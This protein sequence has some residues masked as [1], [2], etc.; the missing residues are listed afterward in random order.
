MFTLPNP[1][2]FEGFDPELEVRL[3]R[4]HLPHW[5]QDGA[6]YFLT[7]RTAD[8]IPASKA[9]EL[10]LLKGEIEAAS[11]KDRARLEAAWRDFV[12]LLERFLDEGHGACVLRDPELSEIVAGAMRHFDGERY[13]LFAYT[14]M[15]NHVHAIV[16]PHGNHGL[17]AILKSWKS[18]SA[19]SIN[20]RLKQGGKFWQAE[21]YDRIVRDGEEL[22]RFIQYIGKNGGKAGLP[23]GSFRRW[24]CQEWEQAGWGF[25]G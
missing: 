19:R 23:Q 10:Q 4:R 21:S 9:H 14:V 15:P 11:E 1:P 7:F 2:G 3:H 16:R 22:Y 6:T 25:V 24:V 18:F 17:G 8:S 12:R 13:A 5:R 20:D